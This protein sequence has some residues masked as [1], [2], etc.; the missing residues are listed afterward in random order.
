MTAIVQGTCGGDRKSG[1]G[2]PDAPVTDNV[3]SSPARLP[4]GVHGHLQWLCGWQVAM[5]YSG[6]L[7]VLARVVLWVEV[8]SGVE[9]E[10]TRLLSRPLLAQRPRQLDAAQ[11]NT[12]LC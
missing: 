9:V 3:R 1:A 5:G 12:P 6:G 10:Q 8:S 4:S 2:D 7:L 11:L